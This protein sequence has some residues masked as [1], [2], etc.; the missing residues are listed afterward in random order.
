MRD[1]AEVVAANGLQGLQLFAEHQQEIALV[2]TD[3]GLPE[4]SGSE[5][6]T[7]IRQLNS[8]VPIIV[9]TGYL[10]PILESEMKRAGVVQF[11]IK[12]LEPSQIL[13]VVREVLDA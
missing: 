1:A 8:S 6:I 4:M 10:D 12:P 11:L 13:R 2:L 9:T 5:E 7:Q 3:I